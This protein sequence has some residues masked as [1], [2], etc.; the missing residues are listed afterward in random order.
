V[1]TAES[2]PEWITA[3]PDGALWF[4]EERASNIGRITTSGEITEYPTPTADAYLFGITAGPDGAL[5]FIE[6]IGNIGQVVL[7][8]SP[9]QDF[10]PPIPMGVS[11]SNTPSYPLLYAG[12]AGLVV[13][14][15]GAPASKFILS[16]N[17]VLG[18][19]GPTLCPSTARAGRTWTLQPGT[20]DIGW[21]PGDDL[22]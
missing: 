20:L 3:G 1:P 19:V 12:T 21:D 8:V 2:V 11:I 18:A 17:H 5:W 9:R 10:A 6:S 4:T 16:N 15:V 22:Y 7:A 13:H 14:S